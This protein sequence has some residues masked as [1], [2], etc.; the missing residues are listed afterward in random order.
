MTDPLKPPPP[1][2]GDLNELAKTA[3]HSHRIKLRVLIA[4]S[5]RSRHTRCLSDCSSA[6]CS[7]DLGHRCGG[8]A[9]L[10]AQ[11]GVHGGVGLA[12]WRPLPALSP[13]RPGRRKA[14]CRRR[15]EEHKSELQSLR[16]L[17]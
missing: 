4:F 6:V 17:V 13:A 12:L 10:R 5:S 14:S 7:S 3:A 1:D 16:H 9:D 11:A 2:A 8:K 15:S